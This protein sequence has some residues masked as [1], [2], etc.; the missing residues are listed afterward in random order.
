MLLKLVPPMAS[1]RSQAASTLSCP[2]S[3]PRRMMP[4]QERKPCWG[5]GREAR[6]F[7]TSW[8]VAFPLV[9]AHRMSRSGVH[10]A[11]L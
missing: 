3:F 9:V 2:Y 7:S 4:K 6:M 1:A 8:A 5:W 10:S 11:Y